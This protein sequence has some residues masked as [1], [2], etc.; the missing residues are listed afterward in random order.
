M[1][2]VDRLVDAPIVDAST[3]P[4]IG[5]NIQGP[6]LIRVPG[7]VDDP[8]GRYY[9]YFADHKGAF[10]RLAYADALA[11]PW[12][13]HEPGSLHLADSHFPTVDLVIDDETY[14]RLKELHGPDDISTVFAEAAVGGIYVEQGRFDDAAELLEHAV[15]REARVVVALLA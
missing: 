9:L 10:I 1:Y 4:S 6:S 12:T 3:H 11:G 8:L 2:R 13:I 7:W 5:H 15:G 14:E